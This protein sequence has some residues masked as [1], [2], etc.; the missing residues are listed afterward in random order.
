MGVFFFVFAKETMVVLFTEEY[1]ES[2]AIFMVYLCTIPFEATLYGN[3]HQAFGQTRHILIAN[4]INVAFTLALNAVLYQPFGL[5][6]PAIAIVSARL[7]GIG[8]HLAVIRRYFGIA[9]CRVFPFSFQLKMLG[10][11][12]LVVS[13]VI[14]LKLLVTS[15]ILV[16]ALAGSA[17]IV[18]YVTVLWFFNVLTVEEKS[19]IMQWMMIRDP[20]LKN[21]C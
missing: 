6:G 13:A 5:L 8:Y 16:L 18:L 11:C 12:G 7:I 9:F 4:I 19:Q 3:I 20:R 1:I 15:N 14:P 17:Y 10:I 2:A 21:V